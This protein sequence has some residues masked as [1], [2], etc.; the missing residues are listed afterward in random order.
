MTGITQEGGA[1]PAGDQPDPRRPV[2]SWQD[3]VFYF[4][5]LIR[6]AG[7][8]P[9]FAMPPHF[10]G[11]PIAMNAGKRDC[12]PS[13]GAGRDNGQEQSFPD[14][15]GGERSVLSTFIARYA[16]TTCPERWPSLPLM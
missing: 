15:E 2:G 4:K 14:P 5:R 12:T 9:R 6:E 10:N 13:F 3:E 16:E 7:A 1:G 11:E 8:A